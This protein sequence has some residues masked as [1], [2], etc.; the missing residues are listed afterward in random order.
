MR[1][2]FFWSRYHRNA[3][4]GNLGLK[5]EYLDF[6]GRTLTLPTT[7]NGDPLQLPLSDFV[8]EL[9][10]DR[11]ELVGQSEWVFP[12]RSKSGHIARDEVVYTPRGVGI[13]RRVH[14]ARS[15]QNVHNH[16]RKP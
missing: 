8:A 5:W 16:R 2:T 4:I 10:A 13:R 6:A 14:F 11:R 9:L 15:A 7:K 12:S 3:S 1:E